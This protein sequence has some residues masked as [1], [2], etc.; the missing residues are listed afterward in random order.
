M[1]KCRPSCWKSGPPRGRKLVLNSDWGFSPRQWRARPSSRTAL[2]EY[3]AVSVQTSDGVA[4]SHRTL[5]P[6]PRSTVRKQNVTI[7]LAALI[8]L[9]RPS[10]ASAAPRY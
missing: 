9:V 2:S 7:G 8:R 10:L 3:P 4:E 5:E 1:V 6:E